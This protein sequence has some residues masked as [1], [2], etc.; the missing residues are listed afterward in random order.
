[1]DFGKVKS[2]CDIDE[3]EVADAGVKKALEVPETCHYTLAG[4]GIGHLDSR[5]AWP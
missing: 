5:F 3:N 2:H 4:V 1:M